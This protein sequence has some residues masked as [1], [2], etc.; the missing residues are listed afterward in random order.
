MDK[1]RT[2]RWG[3]L[4]T[5]RIA[6]KVSVAIQQASNAELKGIASRSTEKASVWASEFKVPASYG[7]YQELLDDPEI[8]AVYIPLPPSLHAEW[9]IKAAEAGK[10]VLCEK[11]LAMDVN[12]AKMMA[13]ACSKNGV[14]LMDGVMWVHHPRTKMMK[15]KLQ[16]NILGELRRVT[17]AIS[18]CWDEIPLQNIRLHKN[19]GGGSLLDMGWYCAR[20]ILWVFD[21]LPVKVFA[22]AKFV[23]EVDLNLSAML[24]FPDGKRASFDCGFDSCMR[25]WFEITGTKGVLNCND[26]TR[27]WDLENPEFQVCD[28]FGNCEKLKS[29]THLQ[30]VRMVENFCDNILNNKPDDSLVNDSIRTQIICDALGESA[31]KE[32]IVII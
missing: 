14:Q 3:I 27:P 18:F 31:E 11:P 15:E 24:W 30:E 17:S 19:L 12:E 23:N 7:H 1:T 5:A 21:E 22:T 32:E 9:T 26:F 16:E 10:H 25:K 6:E 4:G 8:D 29:S 13:D 28:T 2:V 20:A